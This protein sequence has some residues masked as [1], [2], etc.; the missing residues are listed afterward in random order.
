VQLPKDAIRKGLQRPDIAARW[1]KNRGTAEFEKY[2]TQT[3][4]WHPFGN[5]WDVLVILDACRYDLAVESPATDQFGQPKRVW[6]LGGNSP[7]WIDRAFSAASS[8]QLASTAYISGNPFTRDAPI[9]QL[10]YHDNLLE[11][12]FDDELG[13]VPPRPVTDRATSAIR[14]GVADR[15]ILHYMQPHLPPVYDSDES[16]EFEHDIIP[17]HHGGG[18]TNYW[19]EA[20]NGERSGEMVARAYRRNLTPVIEDVELLLR[21]VD[22]DTVTITAD[23]GNFLGERGRWGHGYATS[24]HPALRVVPLYETSA[25]DDQTHQPAEYDRE[26]GSTTRMERLEA[27]GY[28]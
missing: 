24:L 6:S 4:G 23:H 15:Y 14:A 20:V 11:Y 27:L 26:S 16:E 5:E 25:T 2:L 10:A 17:P 18:D 21:N 7:T 22:A 19:R 13:T 12:A 28:L 1:L 8:D 3:V 9:K